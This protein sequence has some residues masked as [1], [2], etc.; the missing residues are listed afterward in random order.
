MRWQLDMAV[1][2]VWLCTSC[3]SDPLPKP[4]GYFRID[5]PEQVY[6]PLSN[7]CFTAEI[8]AHA[9]HTPREVAGHRCWGDLYHAGLKATVHFT[10]RSVNDDLAELIEDAHDF[11]QKHEAK[12]YR[13]RPQ[14]VIRPADRVFGTFFEVEGD[15]ASPCVFY[16]TDSTQHFLYAALY[17][18]ARPNADSLAPVTDRMRED[19]RHFANTLLWR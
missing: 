13:I 14:R 3:G 15:V 4:R 2:C 19:M 5:L 18:N 12:A 9:V 7:A 1:L 17:F 11:K 16:L 6:V 8:P 10:Y